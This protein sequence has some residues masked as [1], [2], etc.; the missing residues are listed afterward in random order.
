MRPSIKRSQRSKAEP[1]PSCWRTPTRT[2]KQLLTSHRRMACRRMTLAMI[3]PPTRVA[4]P[5]RPAMKLPLVTPRK[6]TASLTRRAKR[7]SPGKDESLQAVASSYGISAQELEGYSSQQDFERTMRLIDRSL[8]TESNRAAP[9]QPP[10]TPEQQQADQERQEVL[11]LN[12]DDYDEDTSKLIRKLQ[13]VEQSQQQQAA[14][15]EQFAQLHQELLAAQQNLE[16]QR[17]EVQFH[18]AANGLDEGLFGRTVDDG[19][20]S[21]ELNQGQQVARRQLWE[22]AGEVLV[23]MQANAVRR[24]QEFVKPP[25]SVLL[26]RAE[27]YA[28]SDELNE[29]QRQ[30]FHDQVAAQ[31]RR[32]RP[33]PTHGRRGSNGAGRPAKEPDEVQRLMND[34]DIDAFFKKAD[35]EGV[36]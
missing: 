13:Q 17:A 24:G 22:A 8:V 7:H 6:V 12:P 5:R 19:G 36:G 20:K 33:V 32:R 4:T 31:S 3:F 15:Q 14:Q 1:Q 25:M 9:P 29:R 10:R 34:P 2:W 16:V 35:E 11:D 27:V 23:G 18:E 30:A 21:V 26:K 28:F